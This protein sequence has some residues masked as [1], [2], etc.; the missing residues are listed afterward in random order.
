MISRPLSTICHL[1]L[2]SI[3]IYISLELDAERVLAVSVVQ[4][5]G[6]EPAATRHVLRPDGDDIQRG[7]QP[8]SPHPSP[9]SRL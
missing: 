1:Q 2:K 4:G 3:H 6:Y 5:A 8:S 7:A 9:A